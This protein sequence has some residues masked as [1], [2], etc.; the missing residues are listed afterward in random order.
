MWLYIAYADLIPCLLSVI[1]AFFFLGNG[2]RGFYFFEFTFKNFSSCIKQAYQFFYKFKIRI[3]LISLE[4][5]KVPLIRDSWGTRLKLY[6]DNKVYIEDL[7]YRETLKE[8]PP[9]C[10]SGEPLSHRSDLLCLYVKRSHIQKFKVSSSPFNPN[11]PNFSSSICLTHFLVV[12]FLRKIDTCTHRSQ[13]LLLHV[14]IWSWRCSYP[15]NEI[16]CCIRV[17]FISIYKGFIFGW[18]LRLFFFVFYW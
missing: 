2:K 17:I 11:P 6:S 18:W 13:I 4:R 8:K 3:H 1:W 12:V 15:L 7:D 9:P 14:T 5:C 10:R 16:K